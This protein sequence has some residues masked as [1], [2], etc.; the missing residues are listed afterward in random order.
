MN[1][2]IKKCMFFLG[3]AVGL[4]ACDDFLD[5]VPKGKAVLKSTEDYLGLVE[6]ATPAYDMTNGWF[7]SGDI[8]WYKEEELKSYTYPLYSVGYYWDESYNRMVDMIESPLYNACYKRITNYNIIVDQIASSDG[9]PEDKVQGEAQARIL[10]AYNYFFLI[11]TFAGPYDPATAYRSPGVI[12]REKMFESLE[13]EGVQQSVGYTYD[14]IQ[15]DIEKAVPDLPTKAGNAFRP[16]KTFGY[17]FKAKVHLFRREY[18]KCIEA[19]GLALAEA[20]QGNHSLWDMTVDYMKY[21]PMLLAA[22]YPEMAIDDPAFAGMNDFVETVW[23]TRISSGY[24]APENL[25]YQFGSTYTDPYPMYVTK[26]VLDLFQKDAD[27]RYRYCIRYKAEHETAPEG[28]SNFS[29]LTLKWNPAGMRLSEVYLM[30]AECYARKGSADDITKAVGY[31]ETLRAHRMVPGRYAPLAPADAEEAFRLVREERRRELFLTC[32]SFFDFRRYATELNET[33]TRVVD[34][35]TYTLLPTSHLMT[36][37]FP[38]KAMQTSNL[39][40]NSK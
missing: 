3:L 5:V 38:L 15:E 21:M 34:G 35:Q 40:Q 11:N 37:P 24:D 1:N 7:I 26:E 12:V 2:T 19:C 27:L 6:D 8:S 10:R 25:L 4:S 17:A 14:F 32:N 16:D 29:T 22:G 9:R 31:L 20:Q 13:E 30:L 18:D 23:K 28:D 33:Q 39:T 36:F